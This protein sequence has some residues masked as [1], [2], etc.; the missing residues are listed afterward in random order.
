MAVA[1][2]AGVP[3]F[4]AVD[5]EGGPVVRIRDGVTP[6]PSQMAIGAVGSPDDA[7]AVGRIIGRELRALGINMN[8]APVLDVNNNPDNPVIGL[9]SFGEDPELVA[10]LGTALARGL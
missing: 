1:S 4:I 10:M 6:L 8:M 9:R 5:Q 7:F 2:G 3:L